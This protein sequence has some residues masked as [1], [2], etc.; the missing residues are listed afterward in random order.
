M[1]MKSFSE[2]GH[3]SN[4][5]RFRF[6][7]CAYCLKPFSPRR[8][9]LNQKY[10]SKSC[11]GKSQRKGGKG[12]RRDFTWRINKTIENWESARNLIDNTI[13]YIYCYRNAGHKYGSR[14]AQALS[15]SK[16]IPRKR[17]LLAFIEQKL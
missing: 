7:N 17:R 12:T 9:S 14:S 5:I 8:G 10:C 1:K 11:V 6:N 3:G 13:E 16:L 15:E 2:T 4:P